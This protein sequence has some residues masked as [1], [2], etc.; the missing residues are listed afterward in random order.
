MKSLI[1]LIAALSVAFFTQT[2]FSSESPKFIEEYSSIEAS[3][4]INE[5]ATILLDMEHYVVKDEKR[6]L[7]AMSKNQEL[8]ENIR[9]IARAIVNIQ[10][11]PLY[12]D[13]P[14]LEKIFRDDNAKVVE[15]E[16][17]Y[18]VSKFRYKPSSKDAE[19]LNS[20]LK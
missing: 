11:K 9:T 20:I 18:M 1:V 3:K 15:Q 14:K 6:H 12:E 5:I 17:A 7:K 4:A 19:I 13:I 16:L 2:S 10:H 8:P